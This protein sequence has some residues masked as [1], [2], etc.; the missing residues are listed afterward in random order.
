MVKASGEIRRREVRDKH[1]REDSHHVA[2]YRD[3][4]RRREKDAATKPCR[5]GKV[6]I[7]SRKRHK[8]KERA[9]PAARIGHVY[10]ERAVGRADHRALLDDVCAN[11]TRNGKRRRARKKPKV[12]S[13]NVEERRKRDAEK[14]EKRREQ[15]GLR[16]LLAEK[17]PWNSDQEPDEGDDLETELHTPDAE[18][19]KCEK[20]QRHQKPCPL[21]RTDGIKDLPPF[22]PDDV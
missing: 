18:K 9:K 15:D 3:R 22:P 7:A 4:H 12:D 6:R 2:K 1:D 13:H 21:G 17:R 14:K 10:G 5:L 19:A 8:R 11:A 20:R 16:R